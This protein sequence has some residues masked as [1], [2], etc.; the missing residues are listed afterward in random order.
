MATETLRV[1]VLILWVQY[2]MGLRMR[3]PL[4]SRR[5]SSGH[6]RRR[7]QSHG[8]PLQGKLHS[9]VVDDITNCEFGKFIAATGWHA[10]VSGLIM[11]DVLL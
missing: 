10:V 11:F 4:Q 8:C 3:R 7:R 1:L 5:R 6:E 9:E 2:V